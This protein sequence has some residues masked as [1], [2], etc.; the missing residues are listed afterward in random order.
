MSMKRRLTILVIC[1]IV[2]LGAA[3]WWSLPEG[4]PSPESLVKSALTAGDS[5]ERVRAALALSQMRADGGGAMAPYMR[6]VADESKD[7]EVIAIAIFTLDNM[8][9]LEGLP[10]Y[11]AAMENESPKVRE[12]GW[13]AIKRHFPYLAEGSV[14]SPN[15]PLETRTA[16]V[17]ELQKRLEVLT[18]QAAAKKRARGSGPPR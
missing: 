9:D 1:L 17:G 2:F 6:R 18:E 8:S 15:A 12:L 3:V 4:E 11:F 16:V 13:L 10:R 7:P 14:F 5:A